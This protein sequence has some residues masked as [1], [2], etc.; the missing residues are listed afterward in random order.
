MPS[1]D[2]ETAK[3]LLTRVPF[4][5][6]PDFLDYAL[7]EAKKTRFDVQT[8]GGLKQYL[9]RYQERGTQRAAA[10]ATQARREAEDKATQRRMDYDRF[11]RAAADRLFSSL[12]AKERAAIEAAAHAKAPRF[13]R[14]SGS[15]AQTMFEIERARITAERHPGNIPSLEEWQ[16]R[17]A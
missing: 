12:P 5:D 10:K 14:G 8:L 7:A 16:R 17:S 4:A 15:L 13:G 3:Y 2:V 9:S 1:K 11:R 6:I